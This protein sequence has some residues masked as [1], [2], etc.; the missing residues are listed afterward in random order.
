MQGGV[1][2]YIIARVGFQHQGNAKHLAKMQLVLPLPQ[3]PIV[4]GGK[5]VFEFIECWMS[6]QVLNTCLQ[7]VQEEC[8]ETT[9]LM[10]ANPACKNAAIGM[11]TWYPFVVHNWNGLDAP[12]IF[13]GDEGSVKTR[14]TPWQTYTWCGG[15]CKMDI[16]VS[17]FD[18]NNN[19]REQNKLLGGDYYCFYCGR[20]RS[21]ADYAALKTIPL[22]IPE[23]LCS[24]DDD[25]V[26]IM[27]MILSAMT[28]KLPVIVDHKEQL[29]YCR[30]GDCKAKCRQMGP[31]QL[32]RVMNENKKKITVLGIPL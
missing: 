4:S 31:P 14:S 24:Q 8:P 10:C 12:D 29:V 20:M 9:H 26:A 28:D 30:E 2:V 19:F 5:V 32:L 23:E 18:M 6:T 17:S 25:E 1:P 7:M 27:E 3:M 21:D 13:P 22:D 16:L 11:C 15:K